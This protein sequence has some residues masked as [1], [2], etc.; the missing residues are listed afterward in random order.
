VL[1]FWLSGEASIAWHPSQYP[2]PPSWNA[3]VIPESKEVLSNTL[4]ATKE[5]FIL[6]IANSL[7]QV[8]QNRAEQ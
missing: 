8:L 6:F 1:Q 4:I 2:S 3:E 5:T 7:L